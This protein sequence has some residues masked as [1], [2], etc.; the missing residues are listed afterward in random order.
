[1]RVVSSVFLI[2]FMCACYAAGHLYYTLFLMYCGFKCY[3]ELVNLQR[4]E[5]KDSK[6]KFATIIE[7]FCPLCQTFYLLP[8][9]FYRRILVD[10][11]RM[12]N[13]KEATP[14]IYNVMFIHHSLICGILLSFGLVMFVLSLE[15][16]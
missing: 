12:V 14:L 16:G 6:N 13:F 8:K 11:D 9:T 5:L 1:M 15:K 10:N 4:N 3:F 7:W 2:S